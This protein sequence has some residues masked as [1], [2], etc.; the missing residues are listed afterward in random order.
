MEN[1]YTKVEPQLEIKTVVFSGY[2]ENRFIVRRFEQ[3]IF[4]DGHK[5]YKS[6][7]KW[8]NKSEGNQLF[9]E[10]LQ[11]TKRNT[12]C[13]VNDYEVTR[14]SVTMSI[15]DYIAKL[16][17]GIDRYVDYIDD[18]RTYK[19]VCENNNRLLDEIELFEELKLLHGK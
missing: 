12:G 9:V 16:D 8:V 14:D 11:G 4:P 3:F 1:K 6:G 18:S 19:S 2:C 7:H 10:L 13:H 17:N 15:D 5:L